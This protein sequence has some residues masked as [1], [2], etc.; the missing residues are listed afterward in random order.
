MFSTPEYRLVS[1]GAVHYDTIAHAVAKIHRETSTPARF[2]AKPGGV[3]TNIARAV[4]Q[5]GVETT[6]VGAVGGDGAAHMLEDQLTREGL[7]LKLVQRLEYSTGQY[8]A[9]HDP[10]GELA[11]ACVDDR[12]LS[13]A[14]DD[15]FDTLL[16]KET[17]VSAGQ[18]L[19]F[20][21]ANM[22]EAMLLR[23]IERI[24]GHFV[25][26]NAVSDAKAPRLRPVLKG[27]DCL[28]L[29]RSEAASLL[30]RPFETP[31]EALALALIDSGLKSFILTDGCGDLRV[32]SRDTLHSFA[33]PTAEIV[34]VTGAGDALT[35]G[36]IAALARGYELH[37]ATR[38][39]LSA[40]ALTL[41]TT[42]A[43]AG[44]LSWQ[45]LELFDQPD[46]L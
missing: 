3:A 28:T 13:E 26:A 10:G 31:S 43:L 36:T 16:D 23:T 35:A 9:F 45:N 27:L 39:G 1:I 46:K 37:D 40:A 19:W 6:L 21:D 14:P 30:H 5:L 24:G 18:A 15:L 7:R 4:S 32:F 8:L 20:L 11:A 17:K 12:V 34:D 38:F 29:N 42:G 33:P 25:I 2:S 22:S 41:R 44:D